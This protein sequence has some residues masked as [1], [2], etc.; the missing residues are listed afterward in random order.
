MGLDRL[1]EICYRINV[2]VL[3]LGGIT[4]TNFTEPLAHGAAGLA[5]IGLFKNAPS[6]GSNLKI[7]LSSR[8]NPQD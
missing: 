1:A 4:M 3:G 7:V 6:L 8:L 5:A 2:P